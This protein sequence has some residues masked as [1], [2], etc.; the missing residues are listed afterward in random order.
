MRVVDL[1]RD[2]SDVIPTGMTADSRFL[3]DTMTEVTLAMAQPGPET[4]ILEQP[5]HV[6]TEVCPSR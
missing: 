4:R 2:M 6:P 5:W 1:D 3:F